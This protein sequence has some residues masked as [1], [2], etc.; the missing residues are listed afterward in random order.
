M[1]VNANRS[2]PKNLNPSGKYFRI[3]PMNT[4]GWGN[5]GLSRELRQIVKKL[6]GLHARP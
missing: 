2:R 4:A 3:S 1:R 6:V 5:L